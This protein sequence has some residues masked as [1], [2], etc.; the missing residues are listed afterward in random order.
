MCAYVRVCVKDF[1]V[2][3]FQPKKDSVCVCVCVCVCARAR[4]R[5]R[6]L[7]IIPL[8]DVIAEQLLLTPSPTTH[9][10]TGRWPIH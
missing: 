8:T 10:D 2:E 3:N 1:E 7:N 4:A 9:N 6:F 5:A